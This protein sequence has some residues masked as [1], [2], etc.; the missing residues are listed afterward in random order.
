VASRT[1]EVEGERWTVCLSG[2]VTNYSKDEVALV[3]ELGTGENSIRRV[4]RFRPFGR[5]GTTALADLSDAFLESLLN[6]SQ[7]AWTSPEL[8]YG[9]STRTD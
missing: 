1:I 7:S 4:C 9:K 2:R 3:F 8:G 6:S 5:A